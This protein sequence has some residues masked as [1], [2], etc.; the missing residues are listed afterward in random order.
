M[1]ARRSRPERLMILIG[2]FDS[3]FVR[4][5]GIALRWYGQAFEHRPYAVFRDAQLIAEFNPLRKVPT[6]VLDDGTVLTE[7]FVCLEHIDERAATEHG[8]DW[9]RLLLPRHGGLRMDGLRLCGLATGTMDKMVTL[10]YGRLVYEQRDD[11]WIERCTRQVL[12]TLGYLDQVIAHRTGPYLVGPRLSHADVAVCCAYTL[13]RE[14]LPDLLASQA[15]PALRTHAERLESMP[16]FAATHQAF[17]IN[18]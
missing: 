13:A 6:L 5:V 7:S 14:A 1:I 17:V 16:E 4:R 10:I 2:Q 18:R 11:A 8:E 15:N 9:D 3:P 12:D